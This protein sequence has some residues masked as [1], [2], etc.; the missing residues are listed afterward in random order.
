MKKVVR[1]IHMD[2]DAAAL[3]VRLAGSPRKQGEYLSKLLRAQAQPDSL[4]AELARMESELARLRSE[5]R[6]R[7]GEPSD[8]G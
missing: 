8:G 4:L 5:V 6:R 2:E 3:L 1:K 7:V